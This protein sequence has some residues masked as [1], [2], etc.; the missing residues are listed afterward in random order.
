M[1]Q[2]QFVNPVSCSLTL[3]PRA[4]SVV[5]RFDCLS[6][7]A[8]FEIAK[9][10]GIIVLSSICKRTASCFGHIRWQTAMAAQDARNRTEEQLLDE[11]HVRG[12]AEE[13]VEEE[14]AFVQQFCDVRDDALYEE[15]C[16]Q[17][18]QQEQGLDEAHVRAQAEQFGEEEAAF[19]QHRCDVR[20]D[21][22]YEEFCWQQQQQE[23]HDFLS[24]LEREDF[25]RPRGW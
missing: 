15:F 6:P 10:C 23:L 11:A 13:V 20:D 18:E 3:P 1:Q 16:L 14:A 19:V 25:W 12:Q 17:Q 5:M 22:I 24:W 2:R 7:E 4:A 21:A 8:Y 9:H